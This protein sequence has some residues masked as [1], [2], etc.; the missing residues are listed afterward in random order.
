M[1][2]DVAN[3]FDLC[4]DRYAIMCV[5]H[6]HVPEE[7]IKFLSAVQMKFEKKDWPSVLMAA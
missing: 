5:K 1:L 7:D 4:D 6:H 2:E 3:L